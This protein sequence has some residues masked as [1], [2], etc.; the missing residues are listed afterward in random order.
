MIPVSDL[1]QIQHPGYNAYQQGIDM[2]EEYYPL[3]MDYCVCVCRRFRYYAEKHSNALVTENSLMQII[4]FLKEVE[5]TDEPELVF[6]LRE[7]IR[8][9]CSEFKEHCDDMSNCFQVP[10]S[11]PM[12]YSNI[13]DIVTIIAC[14]FAG[15][16]WT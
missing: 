13:G 12:F 7:K 3:F 2:D 15:V 5:D 11:L 4:D 6:P 1:M 14:D 10:S 8:I 16:E 9:A